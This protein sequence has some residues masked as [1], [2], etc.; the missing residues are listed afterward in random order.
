MAKTHNGQPQPI[1]P[2]VQSA[3]FYPNTYLNFNGNGEYTKHYYNGTERIASRLG[4]NTTTI[5]INND[6][7]LENRKLLSEEQFRDNIHKLIEETVSIDLPPFM[8]VN[9]LQP[10]GTPNDVFY[11]HPNH[12]GSTAYVTDQNQ[13]ITQGFL[14]APFGEITTEYAPLWQ[15]GT[16]PKYSFNAKELDEETGMYYYE[17]RYYKPPV[18]TSRDPMFEKYFWMTPYAYCA[19]N[20]VKYVDPSG[21]EVE[22]NSFIDRLIVGLQ[23]FFNKDFRKQFKE[24]KKSDETYV[25]RKNKEGNNNFTT[26]GNK[27]YINYSMDDNGESKKAG[28]TIFTH[29][30]HET[31]H[32]IQFEY[33]ELGFVYNKQDNYWMPINYDIMDEYEAFNSQN[34]GF[35]WNTIDKST[36]D[37]WTRKSTT[38]EYKIDALKK[39]YPLIPLE[40][41]ENTNTEKRKDTKC[42]ALPHRQRFSY[43]QSYNIEAVDWIKFPLF[44]WLPL[45]IRKND[46]IFALKIFP[47]KDS[48]VYCDTNIYLCNKWWI[49]ISIREYP[50]IIRRYKN[51]RSSLEYTL[52][53]GTL[54][55]ADSEVK[56]KQMRAYNNDFKLSERYFRI[57]SIAYASGKISYPKKKIKKRILKASGKFLNQNYIF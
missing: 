19:N 30:R 45:D 52:L 32:G 56:C 4:D 5:A 36:R 28:Q 31:T 55:I 49:Q 17:A 39:A 40:P 21:E 51:V 24:L 2:M 27:L 25:F 38:T 57:G 29:L 9:A 54:F 12:L 26:D 7:T 15:N 16:L 10:T 37:I 35:R 50:I 11:Y 6:N 43:G 1:Q 48:V 14:Y 53:E 44:E 13:N 20:P 47:N 3:M 42:Y 18:F 8:D 22:Y 46:T 33:G 23:K 34:Y 41:L